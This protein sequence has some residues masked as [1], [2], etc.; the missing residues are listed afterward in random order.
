MNIKNQILINELNINE[1]NNKEL[2]EKIEQYLT[3]K[4]LISELENKLE[5]IANDLSNQVY[6]TIGLQ[7]QNIRF[8]ITKPKTVNKINY[9]KTLEGIENFEQ[10]KKEK[11]SKVWD[12][13]KIKNE[14][15]VIFEETT[16]KPRIIIS[17]LIKGE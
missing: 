14:L 1:K 5:N 4:N 10:Y 16:T 7:E 11:I 8:T 6:D 2:K 12:D 3:T 9:E 17:E 13:D 15:N